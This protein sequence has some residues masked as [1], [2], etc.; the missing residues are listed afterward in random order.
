MAPNHLG[1]LQSL[2]GMIHHTGSEAS[3]WFTR[4][5]LFRHPH[6]EGFLPAERK[7]QERFVAL[8]LD[9]ILQCLAHAP[10]HARGVEPFRAF[11]RRSGL[12]R[13]D[14]LTA[15]SRWQICLKLH[16]GERFT[17]RHQQACTMAAME[18]LGLLFPAAPRLEPQVAVDWA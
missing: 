1:A 18:F 5:L 16:L 7:G 8:I 3:V 11:L 9:R 4:D 17:L 15:F 14:V 12:E 2:A 13:G 6:L 10:G